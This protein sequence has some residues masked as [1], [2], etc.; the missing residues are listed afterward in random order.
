MV[1]VFDRAHVRDRAVRVLTFMHM[2]VAVLAAIADMVMGMRMNRHAAHGHGCG[3]DRDHGH[4]RDRMAVRIFRTVFMD[5]GVLVRPAFD[6]HFPAPHPQ[7]MAI[8]SPDYSI[9]IS[10]TRISVPPVGCT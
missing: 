10:L 2:G 1:M 4:D 8:L 3:H 5:M 7:T 6:L 9:S